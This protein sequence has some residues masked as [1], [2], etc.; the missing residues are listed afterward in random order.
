M[1][2]KIVITK[3]ELEELKDLTREAEDI[4]P[5]FILP[6]DSLLHNRDLSSYAWDLVRDYWFELG[7]KYGFDPRKVKGID[8][9]TGEIVF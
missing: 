4:P 5:I 1:K 9:K 8:S 2:R 7:K 6:E 3:D